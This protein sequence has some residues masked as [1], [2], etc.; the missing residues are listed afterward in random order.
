VTAELSRAGWATPNTL[1]LCVACGTRTRRTV[2]P[3]S[4]H[5]RACGT[6]ASTLVPRVTE[7]VGQLDEAAREVGLGA[8]RRA[9]FQRVLDLL[10]PHLPTG[11]RVLDVG[12]A[13]GWFVEAALGRGLRATGIEPDPE[14]AARATRR[15]L[16]V[17]LGFFPA[18]VRGGPF[19]AIT[20]HDV[21]EHLPDPVGALRACHELLADGG[22]LVLQLPNA[23]GLGMRAAMLLARL[24]AHG[25]YDRFWQVGFPS[26]HL[27]YFSRRGLER[28]A[29]HHGFD[30]LRFAPL[31]T[32]TRA[33][34]WQ[35]MHIDRRPNALSAL[36][37][38]ALWAAVPLLNRPHRSDAMVLI[39]RRD[40]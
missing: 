25:A 20:F 14:V 31:P 22:L 21:F 23:E 30:I 33:G 32:V 13:H 35:R 7:G 11:A 10:A 38:A 6:W 3:Y 26:P 39:L 34:L 18:D 4:F 40:G 8:I 2:R 15:G 1:P 28:L 16:P 36:Q 27:W 17:Q 19:D 29:H 9:N 5:C 37:Y 12:A 24:R